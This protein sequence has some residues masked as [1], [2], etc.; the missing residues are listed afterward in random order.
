[1]ISVEEALTRILNF[2]NVLGTEDKHLLDCLGQVLAEDVYSTINVPP[3]DNSAMDGYA[4]KA[5]DILSASFEYPKT[6]QVIGE[7]PAGTANRLRIDPGTSI[8]IMTGA[9]L[10]EGADVVVPFEDTDEQDHKYKSNCTHEINIYRNLT[11]GTNIRRCGEDITSGELII[12]Q[13]KILHPADIGLIASVGKEVVS[14]TCRPLVGILVTGNEVVDINKPLSPGK[15]Y[16]SNAYSL[17]AQVVKY[18]GIPKLLGIAPDNMEQLSMAIR[19]GLDCDMLITSGG[20]SKG[21]Y[22]IVK[23]V[24]AN[25]GDI[26]FQTVR[27]KPGKPLAFG[28]FNHNGRKVPHLGLPGNPVSSMITFEIFARPAIFKMMGKKDLIRS[29]VKAVMEDS[30]KNSD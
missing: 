27:M 24:L 5:E 28:T 1:M 14:V 6:L 21:D 7:L 22:D 18:G 26:S 30:V 15:I 17:A 3:E 11:A 4:L 12:S 8:R 9:I 19:R 13:G 23:D 10:P 16:N 29:T 2:V 20:V 25:E